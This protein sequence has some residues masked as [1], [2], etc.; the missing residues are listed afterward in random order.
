MEDEKAFNSRLFD[1]Q[2]ELELES[3]QHHPDHEQH[4]A[5]YFEVKQTPARGIKVVAKDE[6][7]VEAKRNFG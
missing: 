6:A 5:K 3:G 7:I 4:Y 2:Q 1:M